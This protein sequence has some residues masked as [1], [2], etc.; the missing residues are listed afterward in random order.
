MVEKSIKILDYMVLVK[1]QEKRNAH[2]SV[3][4]ATFLEWVKEMTRQF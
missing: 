4:K 1:G 3:R 2:N